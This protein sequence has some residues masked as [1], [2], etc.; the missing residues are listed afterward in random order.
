MIQYDQYML[1][2][3]FVVCFL[4]LHVPVNSSI[5]SLIL[6]PTASLPR[7]RYQRTI[8]TQTHLV[9]SLI[10]PAQ[11]KTLSLKAQS[12]SPVFKSCITPSSKGCLSKIQD[13]TN[14]HK[15]LPESAETGQDWQ[16]RLWESDTD[17]CNLHSLYYLNLISLLET[18]LKIRGRSSV[19]DHLPSMCRTLAQSLAQ[20]KK[21]GFKRILI[22]DFKCAGRQTHIFANE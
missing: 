1:G 2:L 7:S 3:C 4:C 21:K 5:F 19:G 20:A 6:P 15:S 18:F 9:T 22:F 11:W 14:E 13:L 12:S 16:D 10:L 17:Q 8:Q